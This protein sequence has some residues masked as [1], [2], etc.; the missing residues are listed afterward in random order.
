VAV[1]TN[2][3]FGTGRLTI[4]GGKLMS[5]SATARAI[6]VPVTLA[7]DVTLGD[8]VNTGVLT[9]SGAWTVSGGPRQITVDSGLS[10]V[11]SGALGGTGRLTK[12][13]NGTLDLTA[14]NTVTGGINHN[15]GTLRVNNNAGLGAA[16]SPVTLGNG[17][18][19]STT[20]G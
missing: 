17:V 11:I 14:A 19:L 4:N 15:A 12:A 18:T 7:G 10:A 20:A 8:S 13:G 9:N 5:D 2:S 3:V 16:N 1:G 6:S